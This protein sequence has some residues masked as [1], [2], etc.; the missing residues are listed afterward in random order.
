MRIIE[1]FNG[2]PS[3]VK[4]RPF[5]V[6]MGGGSLECINHSDQ[7][8]TFNVHFDPKRDEVT[9]AATSEPGDPVPTHLLF[10]GDDDEGSILHEGS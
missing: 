2:R 1:T 10:T 5:S 4:N 7:I 8:L 9:V 3:P 6:M